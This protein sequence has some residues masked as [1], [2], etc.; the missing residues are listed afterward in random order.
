MAGVMIL[1]AFVSEIFN[2]KLLHDPGDVGHWWLSLVVEKYRESSTF[3][4]RQ[5]HV[6][7][8]TK[9]TCRNIFLKSEA[10]L[11]L[12]LSDSFRFQALFKQLRILRNT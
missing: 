11:Y 4:S 1:A 7:A 9:L 5:T 8:C 2:I 3:D 6:P 12:Q 10:L